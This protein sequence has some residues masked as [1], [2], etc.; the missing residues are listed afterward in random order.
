[1]KVYVDIVLMTIIDHEIAVLCIKRARKDE[2]FFNQWALPGGHIPEQLGLEDTVSY[3]LDRELGIKDELFMKQLKTFGDVG[4]DPRGRAFSIAYLAILP[5][6]KINLQKTDEA[7]EVKWFKLSELPLLAFD[8]NKI[9]KVAHE[10]VVDNIRFTPIGF[11]LI[12]DEFTMKS[13]VDTFSSITGEEIEQSNLR[14]KLLKMNI[15]KET[16]RS[17][18]KK[19]GR[20]API[21]KLNRGVLQNIPQTECFFGKLKDK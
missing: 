15:I 21:F 9:V 1:M 2:P 7:K 13:L 3:Q 20:P 19:K 16:N 4:R 6:D 14:N 11:E 17:V 5:K 12:G 8:H 10:R 18:K